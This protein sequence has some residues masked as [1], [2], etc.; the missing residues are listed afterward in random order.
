MGAYSAQ[1]LQ[2]VAN[3]RTQ[4]EA[5]IALATEQGF[6]LY[7]ATATVVHGWTLANDGRAEEGIAEIRQGLA[8]YGATGGPATRCRRSRDDR[9]IDHRRP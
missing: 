7:L 4:A 2:D 1:L 3:A 6:P 9:P 8:G 5:V